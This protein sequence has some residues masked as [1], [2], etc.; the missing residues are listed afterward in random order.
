MI[1]KDGFNAIGSAFLRVLRSLISYLQLDQKERPDL[2]PIVQSVLNNSSSPHRG[3]VCPLMAF[4]AAT[5]L[6]QLTHS[7][8][9]PRP[10]RSPS[11]TCSRNPLKSE[12]L[13]RLCADLHHRVQST[14]VEC[15]KQS[16]E[17][18]SKAELPNFAEVYYVLVARSDFQDREKA[19]F[20]GADRIL[21][22][23]PSTSSFTKSKTT[24]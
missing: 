20:V 9:P 24:Q 11:P 21:F 14:L 1:M 3:N 19:V 22:A 23:R 4:M 7:S 16:R 2:I 15:K 6:Y 12:K 10:R 5:R 17:A 13:V 8:S 18:A